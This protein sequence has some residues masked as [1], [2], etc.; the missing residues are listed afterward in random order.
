M[1]TA[2]CRNNLETQTKNLSDRKESLCSASPT[3][4]WRLWREDAADHHSPPSCVRGWVSQYLE[5]STFCE[6]ELKEFVREL[7]AVNDLEDAAIHRDLVADVEVLH[8]V[9]QVV[10]RRRLQDAVTSDQR[11]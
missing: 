4:H 8:R 9:V 11:P 10:Q 7:V 6:A 2:G 5:T 3:S 1:T